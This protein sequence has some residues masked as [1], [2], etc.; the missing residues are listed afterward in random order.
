MRKLLEESPPPAAEA[1]RLLAET[2]DD[3]K[4]LDVSES[5]GIQERTSALAVLP[6]VAAHG[7]SFMALRIGDVE[8]RIAS[9]FS[10][11]EGWWARLTIDLDYAARHINRRTDAIVAASAL[12]TRAERTKA[13]DE[14][15]PSLP[16]ESRRDDPSAV[17]VAEI[18]DASIWLF[19]W[20]MQRKLRG[21]RLARW[22]MR[23]SVDNTMILHENGSREAFV[24]HVRLARTGL[25]LA[26]YRQDHGRFPESLDAL[27]PRY[28]RS[29]PIDPFSDTAFKYR[30][31]DKGYLLYSVGE[32]GKDDNGQSRWDDARCEDEEAP[33]DSD[34]RAVKNTG[35][36][37][38]AADAK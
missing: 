29:V 30:R 36:A 23:S 3:P 28:V 37:Y 22:S 13:F 27:A 14:L 20:N 12:P 38:E 6:F 18:Q 35:K 25:A 26:A 9:R 16:E 11:F 34:D 19:D 10:V 17:L 1:A 15:A 7:T 5:V 8:K 33:F 21:H 32:N 24:M 31:V 2:A 4:W